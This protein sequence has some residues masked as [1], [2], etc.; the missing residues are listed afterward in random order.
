MRLAAYVADAFAADPAR[1][2]TRG[3]WALSRLGPPPGF[4]TPSRKSRR[5]ASSLLLLGAPVAIAEAS[6]TA[7]ATNG[8]V[9]NIR[10]RMARSVGRGARQ[11]AA[12]KSSDVVGF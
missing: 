6:F 4:I 7:A 5:R 9:D 12:A 1:A 11:P 8:R 2:A 10:W 3:F